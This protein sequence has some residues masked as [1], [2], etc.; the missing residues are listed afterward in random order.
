MADTDTA[1]TERRIEI[2]M[3]DNTEHKS[4][5]INESEKID[6]S[7][8]LERLLYGV[9]RIGWLIV[10]L[11]VVFAAASY[12]RTSISYVPKFTAEATL[13]IS[14]TK[15]EVGVSSDNYADVTTAQQLGKIFPYI[16][17]SGVL[18]DLVAQDLGMDT[19]PGSISVESVEDTNMLTISVTASDGQTAY[20]VLQSVLK[21]YPEVAQFVV[22]QTEV[23]ILDDSGV[24]S[25]SGEEYV[26]KGSVKK[27]AFAGF[28]VGMIILLFYIALHRTIRYPGDFKSILN[29]P[30]L[31]TIPVY[32]MKKRRKNK[33][34]VISILNNNISQEYLEALRSVR[35]RV[36]RKM[37][38]EQKKTIMV[39]SS[40]PGEGKSTVAVNLALSFAQKGKKV[41]LVDCDLRNPSVQE[42][43]K[44]EGE[45]PGIASI[46]SG[47]TKLSDALYKIPNKD[48]D[49]QVLCGSSKAS[50]RVEILGTEEMKT[51]L[52]RLE[53]MAD[54]V[55]LDT[56]PSAMLVD[57]MVMAHYVPMALYV[58]KYDYAKVRHILDGIEELSDTGINIIGCVL[59]EGKYSSHQS[60]YGYRYSGYGRYGYSRY[61]SREKTSEQNK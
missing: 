30:C 10:V 42:K 5:E 20:D 24:P 16:L 50:R 11:T 15:S 21:N 18:S 41:I 7:V 6:L 1:N 61:Y 39:T 4:R 34:Q 23:S 54:L 17:T 57:A 27:G 46:L 31:G 3:S 28:S 52:N 36:E 29:I 22:G 8:F 9:K 40:V 38:N 53:S 45:F 59:N 25:D 51:L 56:S 44:I 43:L 47:D 14:S 60:S 2:I 49:L 35:T 55:I 32:K 12:F 37:E 48:I 13:T 58:V 26:T 33:A 19:V